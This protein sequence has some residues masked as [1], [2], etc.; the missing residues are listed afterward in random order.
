MLGNLLDNACKWA[1]SRV[2]L[3]IEQ[4]GAAYCVCIDDDGPGIAESQREQVQR[5]GSRLDEQSVGH[6]LGLGIVRD[7]VETLQGTLQLLDSPLGGLRVE[8]CLRPCSA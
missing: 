4:R 1:D 8:I 3:S 7:I 2:E 5:R 6:G